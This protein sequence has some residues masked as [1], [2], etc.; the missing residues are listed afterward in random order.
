MK[1]CLRRFVL[2]AC[3]ALSAGIFRLLSRLKT[4]VYF[5]RSLS[6][7]PAGSLV[8]FPLQ[9]TLLGCGIAGIVALKRPASAPGLSIPAVAALAERVAARGFD[10]CT[11]ADG[12]LA[13]DYLG[14]AEG[15]EALWQSVLGLK[16][17]EAFEALYADDSLQSR[18]ASLAALLA[19]RAEVEGRRFG[20]H[21]GRLSGADA[22]RMSQQIERLRDIAWC[23]RAETLG[24][25]AKVRELA[26]GSGGKVS[27]RALPVFRNL[28]AVLNSI[29]RMEVR[30]RDSA[31]VSLLFTLSP[32]DYERFIAALEKDGRQTEFA[33]RGETEPLLNRSIS[34][35]RGAV[36]VAV[37]FTYKVAVEIGRLG[38]N[39]RFLRREIASDPI[40]QAIAGFP[41]EFHTVNAHTRWASV[42]AIT[43]AN[44]HP[45]DN[46]V[47]NGA[48]GGR[49]RS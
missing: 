35:H 13:D 48:A 27:A 28:N 45:V 41:V 14:G 31:G 36:S 3:P 18:I 22:D 17:Q 15:I 23:L 7:V 24:N 38:D 33:R 19:E 32:A 9:R 34:V 12:R 37:A 10:A 26:A 2:C 20:E 49:N 8:V 44:C 39:I 16:R 4:P 46:R 40:L 47:I 5:G 1:S 43:E 30:G 42:G 25:L 29:D 21:M 11:S 6:N